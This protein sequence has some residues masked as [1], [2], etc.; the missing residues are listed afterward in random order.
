MLDPSE[1]EVTSVTDNMAKLGSDYSDSFD[2]VKLAVLDSDIGNFPSVSLPEPQSI[3]VDYFLFVNDIDSLD[4]TKKSDNN[5]KTP[6]RKTKTR[7]E[8]KDT[9]EYEKYRES[10][11]LSAR[12][13]RLQAKK[14][15]QAL[16]QQTKVLKEAIFSINDLVSDST[17]IPDPFRLELVTAFLI[18]SEEDSTRPVQ[19]CTPAPHPLKDDLGEAPSSNA[20]QSNSEDMET[21]K[22]SFRERNNVACRKTRMKMKTRKLELVELVGELKNSIHALHCLVSDIDATYPEDIKLQLAKVVQLL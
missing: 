1:L 8:C 9:E 4:D 10:N 3:T 17:D 13:N 19:G 21:G 18:A 12:K 20:D 22:K 14:N 6:K 15:M 2:L 11:N 16:E 7:R 5:V